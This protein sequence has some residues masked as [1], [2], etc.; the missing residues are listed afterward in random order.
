MP[1]INNTDIVVGAPSCL[2]TVW[3]PT[4]CILQD[5]FLRCPDGLWCSLTLAY[6][7][8]ETS[9]MVRP[10]RSESP[11]CCPAGK[12]DPLVTHSANNWQIVSRVV[13]QWR[14]IIKSSPRSSATQVYWTDF[15]R[16]LT[17]AKSKDP[18][19]PSDWIQ[20]VLDSLGSRKLLL[21][22]LSRSV[23]AH[24]AFKGSCI[25]ILKIFNGF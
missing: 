7:F 17:W 9:E 1:E 4:W 5:A 12:L 25:A 15:L 22:M 21:S 13:C 2:W 20:N 19:S 16:P 24:G 18:A 11:V 10:Q 14:Q 6:S 8:T 23:R 3:L